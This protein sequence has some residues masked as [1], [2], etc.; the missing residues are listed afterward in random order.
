MNP[1][2]PLHNLNFY[3]SLMR[4]RARFDESPASDRALVVGAKLPWRDAALHEILTKRKYHDNV[5]GFVVDS[6]TW[7]IYSSSLTSF[8]R[9]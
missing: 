5:P 9:T 8:D 4:G 2:A 6:G 1:L 3:F 7:T